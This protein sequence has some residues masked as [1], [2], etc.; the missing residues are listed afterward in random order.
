[1][2]KPVFLV[3]LFF[4]NSHLFFRRSC[5]IYFP[6]RCPGPA[7]WRRTDSARKNVTG[8][9]HHRTSTNK[10]D[11]FL[12]SVLM[13]RLKCIL[14][15]KAHFENVYKLLQVKMFSF[16]FI[17]LAANDDKKTLTKSENSSGFGKYCDDKVSWFR[18]STS[19]WKSFDCFTNNKCDSLVQD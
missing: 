9:G 11:N 8:A 16:C 4:S 17:P 5:R 15:G 3:E 1:M 6:R 10:E 7:R 19:T 14:Y 18:L 13:I 2:F 12:Y